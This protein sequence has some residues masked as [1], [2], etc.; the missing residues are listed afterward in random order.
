MQ[1][2]DVFVF[3]SLYEGLPV[4]MIEAQ[5]AGLPCVIS[6]CVPEECI[7]TDELVVTKNLRDSSVEWAQEIMCCANKKKKENYVCR[8]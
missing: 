1:A 3:P 8:L 5:A 2:M 4:T 7:V 6:D